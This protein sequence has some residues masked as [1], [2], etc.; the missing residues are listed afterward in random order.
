MEVMH[1]TDLFLSL[2]GDEIPVQDFKISFFQDDYSGTGRVRGK[3]MGGDI[4]LMIENLR[5]TSLFEWAIGKTELKSGSV[6][7][8]DGERLATQVAFE[9]GSLKCLDINWSTNGTISMSITIVAQK[10]DL[11]GVE[12]TH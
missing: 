1:L 4:S 10:I 11:M 5:V 12:Y 2:D 6:D 8:K 3:V 7:F 9:E